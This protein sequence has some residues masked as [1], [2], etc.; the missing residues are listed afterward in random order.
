M[1]LKE[2]GVI[3]ACWVAVWSVMGFFVEIEWCG[4]EELNY[5]FLRGTYFELYRSPLLDREIIYWH[6][7]DATIYTSLI[8]G[9]LHLFLRFRKCRSLDFLW[10]NSKYLK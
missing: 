4:T 3:L 8:L 2:I 7:M 10:K 9:P 1:R 6:A 5:P